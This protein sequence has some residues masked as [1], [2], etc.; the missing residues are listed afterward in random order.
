MAPP[1]AVILGD[2]IR[3]HSPANSSF[4]SIRLKFNVE[5]HTGYATYGCLNLNLSRSRMFRPPLVRRSRNTSASTAPWTM[6]APTC[7]SPPSGPLRS[8]STR[9]EGQVSQKLRAVQSR[10]PRSAIG[11]G[12]F[13]AGA[14]G[15]VGGRRVM[16]LASWPPPPA[17]DSPNAHVSGPPAC[18]VTGGQPSGF[19][20]PRHE[21]HRRFAPARGRDDAD[22][23]EAH[24][25]E[26][27]GG[28][29]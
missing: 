29:R 25:P 28:T 22:I 14:F 23:V 26:W 21:P 27:R 10:H 9:S 7:L 8:R 17:R 24:P 3:V 20:A 12:L 4:A 18:F 19:R 13:W 2:C 1:P 5:K 16:V 11:G 15:R 6:R